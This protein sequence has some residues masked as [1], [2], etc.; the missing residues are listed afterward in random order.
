MSS[1][2][3]C[4]VLHR[5]AERQRGREAE[6]ERDT[7][8]QTRRDT[9]SHAHRHT[10]RHTQTHSHTAF[11]H[12]CYT[13]MTEHSSWLRSSVLKHFPFAVMFG[14]TVE[15]VCRQRYA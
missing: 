3:P 7:H 2:L 1:L 6:I 9:H 11:E 12:V 14:C 5:E 8:T 4:N 13:P 15:E 10:R